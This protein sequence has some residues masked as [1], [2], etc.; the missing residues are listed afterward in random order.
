MSVIVK[1]GCGDN[2]TPEVTAQTPL[3]PLIKQALVGKSQGAGGIDFGEVTCASPAE[4]VT[5][6]H[7]L[8]LAPSYVLLVAK[9]FTTVDGYSYASLNHIM[10]VRTA[11][12]TWTLIGKAPTKTDT[13]ITFKTFSAYPFKISD[14]YWVAIV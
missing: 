5:V 9:D 3:L 6:A 7:S 13:E 2:V 4:T 12:S 1:S 10:L 8:G 14:Y 11:A